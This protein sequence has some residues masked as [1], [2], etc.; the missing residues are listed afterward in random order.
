MDLKIFLLLFLALVIVL[1]LINNQDNEIILNDLNY[2]VIDGDTIRL[3]NIYYRDLV[4]DTPEKNKQKERWIRMF[5][6]NDSCLDKYYLKA[7]NYTKNKIYGFIS[8]RKKDNYNR[9]LVL[10]INIS[11]EPLSLELV[12]EGLAFCYYRNIKDNPSFSDLIQKCLI[13]EEMARQKA[14][15]IWSC[16]LS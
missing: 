14:L 5:N 8:Y 7:L 3:N 6:L 16:K 13:L 15:G 2:S 9:E 1:I 12:S 10:F 4:M 11:K